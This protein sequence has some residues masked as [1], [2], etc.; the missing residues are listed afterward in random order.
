MAG[1]DWT[2]VLEVPAVTPALKVKPEP[3]GMP[4]TKPVVLVK[5]VAPALVVY[6]HVPPVKTAFVWEAAR[7]WPIIQFSRN[8][9]NEPSDG[10]PLVSMPKR[11]L[12]PLSFQVV[13]P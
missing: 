4:V 6:F 13:R 12:P 11:V 1:T 2:R 7:F 5:P 9:N 8:S 10:R 3:S